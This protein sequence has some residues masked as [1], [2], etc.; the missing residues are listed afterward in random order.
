MISGLHCWACAKD[1]VV[2]ERDR[3]NV[4]F[5]QSSDGYHCWQA[6]LRRFGQQI[7]DYHK[8]LKVWI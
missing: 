7:T 4:K 1:F 2:D 5:I 3:Q 6:H 8:L